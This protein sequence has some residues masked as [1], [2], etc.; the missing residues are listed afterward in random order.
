MK[1]KIILILSLLVLSGCTINYNL[2]YTEE[3]MI[4]T[5]TGNV[6]KAESEVKDSDSGLN[7]Y[8]N[9]INE[10]QK[11]FID[12]EELYNKNIIENKKDYEYNVTNKYNNNLDKSTIINYCFKEF[13]IEDEE[14]Y[15]R[16][17]LGGKFYCL[18]AD[19]INVNISSD[20]AVISSNAN[21]T[22]DNTYTWILNDENDSIDI[23]FSKNIKYVG[24]TKSRGISSTF[25]IVCFIVLVVLSSLAYILYKKKNSSEI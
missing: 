4:E 1:K 16:I 8:Y 13:N 11:V 18:Y 9:L 5:I 21:K 17:H 24:T 10:P 7:I 22:K 12:S 20:Y 2:D 3:G 15:Y 14:D 6:T 19:K 23:T 25:R